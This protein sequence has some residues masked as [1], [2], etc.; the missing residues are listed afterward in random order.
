MALQTFDNN[1]EVGTISGLDMSEDQNR[2]REKKLRKGRSSKS[3]VQNGLYFF[4][5]NETNLRQTKK[6]SQ[7]RNNGRENFKQKRNTVMLP[8]NFA[9]TDTLA[10]NPDQY[11][12]Y[13]VT[14]NHDGATPSSADYNI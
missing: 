10:L 5:D 12:Q 8:S 7:M 13:E 11:S 9:R 1:R 6:E 14:R 3:F 4:D 2:N